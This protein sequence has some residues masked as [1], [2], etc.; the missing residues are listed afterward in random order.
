MKFTLFALVATAATAT[1][2]TVGHQH[3][4]AIARPSNTSGSSSMTSS[5][6]KMSEALE[7]QTAF[8]KAEIE[9]NDVS[10]I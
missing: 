7:T 1:A 8:A 2:F 9:S 4:V 10:F 5:S 3:V 6:L